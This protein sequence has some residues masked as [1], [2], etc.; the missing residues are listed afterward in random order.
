M[1]KKNFTPL[2]VI[3]GLVATLATIFALEKVFTKKSAKKGKKK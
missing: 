3:G 1:A 2:K